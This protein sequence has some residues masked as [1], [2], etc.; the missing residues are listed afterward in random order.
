MSNTPRSQEY[1]DYAEG[2][3]DVIPTMNS[4]QISCD[5]MVGGD[6]EG[7]GNCANGMRIKKLQ[8]EIDYLKETCMGMCKQLE[9][10]TKHEIDDPTK[11]YRGIKAVEELKEYNEDVDNQMIAVANSYKEVKDKNKELNEE[12]EKLND[13][14]EQEEKE[15]E[16]P[17]TEQVSKCRDGTYRPSFEASC[18]N[19]G[20]YF[21]RDC[22]IKEGMKM[23]EKEVSENWAKIMLIA[24]QK[25]ETKLSDMEDDYRKLEKKLYGEHEWSSDEDN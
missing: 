7:E 24:T 8:E 14:I 1:I 13:I 15:K 9:D 12:I 16:C 20:A 21:G 19:E 18:F 5:C 11:F 25:L 3:S 17:H 2:I 4:Q 10:A 6:C 22:G 23:N